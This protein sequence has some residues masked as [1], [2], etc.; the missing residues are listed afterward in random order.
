MFS[1]TSESKR[2]QLV[3][4]RPDVLA[5]VLREAVNLVI[6]DRSLPVHVQQFAERVTQLADPFAQSLVMDLDHKGVEPDLSTLAVAYRDLEGPEGFV[7]DIAW[8]TKAFSYL[9]DARRI[10]IRL[11]LLDKAMCPRF[12]TD[13]VPLRRVTTYVGP[14]SLWSDSK[15]K[16]LDACTIHQLPTGA[17]GILKG[18]AWEGN[19]QGAIVHCSPEVILGQRHLFLSLDWLA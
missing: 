1:N 16:S 17:V 10:G 18:D 11:R 2:V 9:V 14:G 6:W 7:A 13:H 4:H 15:H 5:E 8:L 12:H 3:D 19:E